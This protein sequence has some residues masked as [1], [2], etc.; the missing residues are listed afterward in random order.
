M[1]SIT[2]K[3]CSIGFLLI[4]SC[5]GLLHQ[6]SSLNVQ[7]KLVVVTDQQNKPLSGVRCGFDA[8]FA[9][10]TNNKGKLVISENDAVGTGEMMFV[11]SDY[12]IISYPSYESVPLLIVMQ[13]N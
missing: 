3:L 12:K 5:S 2:L 7:T 10:K 13:G 4:Q 8:P 1:K 6:V 9:P 11:H